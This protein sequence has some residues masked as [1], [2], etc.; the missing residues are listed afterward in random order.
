MPPPPAGPVAGEPPGGEGGATRPGPVS[1]VRLTGAFQHVSVVGDPDRAEPAVDGDCRQ[2]RE[3]DTLV[4]EGPVERSVAAAVTRTSV[5]VSVNI[6]GVVTGVSSSDQVPV[7]V[8]VPPALE[9]ST[10]LTAGTLEVVGLEGAVRAHAQTGAVSVEGCSGPVDVD[11]GTG[12][13]RWRGVAATGPVRVVCGTGSVDLALGRGSSAAVDA[14][15]G[16]GT[17]SVVGAGSRPGPSPPGTGPSRQRFAL[18]EGG[19]AVEAR[20]EVGTLKITAA[21]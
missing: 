15:V 9:L 18:G 19:A 14:S 3:G 1:R 2:R 10:D 17:L 20:V 5:A 11:V 13:L 12:T 8:R 6:T 7:T 16:T 4:V 21:S